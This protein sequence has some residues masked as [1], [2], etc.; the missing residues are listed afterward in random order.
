MGPSITNPNQL[1]CGMLCC[2]IRSH[3]EASS[4]AFRVWRSRCSSRGSSCL[5]IHS[6]AATKHTCEDA[7]GRILT[8]PVWLR[9]SQEQQAPNTQTS[10]Q[11]ASTGR[12]Q[13]R[14]NDTPHLPIKR[15]GLTR[16]GE[17]GHSP[18]T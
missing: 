13:P 6:N 14:S 18:C 1:R 17:V 10:T 9:A 7:I 11:T 16:E 2:L 4:T 5:Q 3:I 8:Q 12:Q 15:P